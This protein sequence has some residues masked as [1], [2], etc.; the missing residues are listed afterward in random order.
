MTDSQLE[1]V[2][3]AI[4]ERARIRAFAA[5]QVWS[6]WDDLVGEA[7]EI[8]DEYR[9]L[10]D[11]ALAVHPAPVEP[12]VAEYEAAYP[13]GTAQERSVSDIRNGAIESLAETAWRSSK[14]F[15]W[16]SKV[17]WDKLDESKRDRWRYIAEDILDALPAQS[18]AVEDVDT[19][20]PLLPL[21]S[22]IG[23]SAS[24]QNYRIPEGTV[25]EKRDGSYVLVKKGF[26]HDV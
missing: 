11:A 15:N 8:L 20:K 3:R 26:N 22:V 18:T 19:S 13:D 1:V 4:Y 21:G 24:L 2:A 23:Y 25:W 9:D 6:V 5:H 16:Q 14:Q 17:S 10:A 12:T 7:E